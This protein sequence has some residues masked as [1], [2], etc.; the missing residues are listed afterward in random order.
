MFK[1]ILCIIICIIGLTSCQDEFINQYDT[2]IQIETDKSINQSILYKEN[3]ETPTFNY[4]SSNDFSNYNIIT[5][6]DNYYVN[7]FPGDN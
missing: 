4:E 2:A 7:K 3:K 5:H 1:K 6:A